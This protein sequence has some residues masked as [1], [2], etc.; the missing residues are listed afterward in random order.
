VAHG[1]AVRVAEGNRFPERLVAE[2]EPLR[3]DPALR[4]ARAVAA[5]ALAY[6]DAA[7]AV[8]DAILAEAAA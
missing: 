1:A 6:P 2:L 8:A 7:Q 4:L 3:A 5:R